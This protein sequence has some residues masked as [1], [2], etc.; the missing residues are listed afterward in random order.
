MEVKM[1]RRD[2]GRADGIYGM[3][4]ARWHDTVGSAGVF[5]TKGRISARKRKRNRTT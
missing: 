5:C 3:L 4:H 2:H 1:V